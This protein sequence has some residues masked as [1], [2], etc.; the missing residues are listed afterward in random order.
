MNIS[1]KWLSRYVTLNCDDATLC[2]KLTTAGIEVEKVENNTTV[3]DGVITAEIIERKPHPDSDHLSVCQ[4]FNGK[5]NIQIVCGA[6]NCDAGKIVPLATIGTVFNTPEGSFKIKKSKLRG[7]ESNGMMCSA[8]EIGISDD[9]SGLYI[10]PDGTAIGIPVKQLF[11]GDTMIEVEVTPNRPDWL[12]M[13]GIARDVSCLLDAPAVLPELQLAESTEQIPD[14]VTVQAPDLCPRYIGRVI[15]GIKVAP[16]P[17]WLVKSLESIGLRSINNVVDV[18]NFILM[19]L[20]QPL[21]AFDL[22]KL[23]G[24]RVIVRRAAE[25]EKIVTLDGKEL[26]LSP[27]NLVIADDSKPMALA[28][29]MGGEFSGVSDDTVD[30][31]LE[32]AVFNPSN[33]RYTS[34]RLGISSDSSYRFERG[35]DFDMAE[36]ASA[37]A[38]QLILE[39]AGGTLASAPMEVSAGRPAEPVIECRFDRIRSLIGMNDSNSEI[40]DIFRKLHLKVENITE[41]G[42]TVTA[43]LFR[44]DLTREADLAEEVA[45]VN[46][47]DKVPEITVQGKV[48][49][50]T[51]EDAYRKLKTLR[52]AVINAGFTECVNYSIIGSGT[53][54][55]DPRFTENDLVK[56]AN[57]L[58]PEVAVMRP[59]LIGTMLGTIERNVSHGNR[60]LALFELGRAFC[61][62]PEIFPEERVELMLV[63]SGHPHAGRFSAESKVEYDF[64]DL[65]GC[66][67]LL[68]EKFGITRYRFSALENDSRF[69]DGNAA[70]IEV[71]GKKVGTA[72]LLSAALTSWKNA[73]P[74]YIAQIEADVFFNA[75]LRKH[76][77]FTALPQ[78]PASSRDIALLVPENITHMQIEEFIRRAKVANLES[79]KLFD[80]FADE[81]LQKNN[82]RSMAY[83]LTFRHPE[84]TLKDDEINSAMDKLRTKLENELKLKSR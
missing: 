52:D 4:V 58:S 74:V 25:G 3:P 73:S 18:T 47:L 13:W 24:K 69:A 79:V 50:S 7:V 41:T 82:C 28:G 40:V 54:L 31:L 48:C 61:S 38:A 83:S 12:S 14:L 6:P 51:A 46:G 2:H 26:T 75:M 76:R 39:T 77:S 29:I 43:P 32:S 11:P 34:R 80:I 70:L 27:E 57:P 8:A 15:K 30:I 81:D 22:D 20:G 68:F 53:A 65:K 44:L 36:F 64:Y 60:E 59:S 66:I 63:L 23:S 37:R 35:V 9:D 1:R 33:I 71:E 49:H 72:G 5:E 78:Y 42:C 84:R 10:F 16:S 56:L 55:T 19:E 45:R 21:H 67:E 17:E 62:N